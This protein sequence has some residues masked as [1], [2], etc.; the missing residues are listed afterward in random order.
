ELEKLAATRAGSAIVVKIDT[1]AQPE[2]SARFGIRSIPTLVMFRGG[3]E[4]KRVSGALPAAAIAS[5]LGL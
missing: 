4:H 3:H 2:L 5:Q 1:D